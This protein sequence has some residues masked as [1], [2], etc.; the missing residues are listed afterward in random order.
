MVNVLIFTYFHFLSFI[1]LFFW[2]TESEQNQNISTNSR[3]K[4]IYANQGS[5]HIL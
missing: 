3:G 4:Q 5:E 1:I 2:R